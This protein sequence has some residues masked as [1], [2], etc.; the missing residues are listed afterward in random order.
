[1]HAQAHPA[2]ATLGGS[3]RGCGDPR[4]CCGQ[5]VLSGRPQ[6][7]L[8]AMTAAERCA[9]RAPPAAG[10]ALR[11]QRTK[12][13]RSRHMS[14]PN[15]CPYWLV[16]E[17]TLPHSRSPTHVMTAA[18]ADGLCLSPGHFC[19]AGPHPPRHARTSGAHIVIFAGALGSAGA[20][21][22][23]SPLSRGAFHWPRVAGWREP[24]CGL[25]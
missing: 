13:R 10:R 5:V 22:S 20:A 3:C 19:T 18:A 9:R 21:C 15:P 1:M 7:A 23:T 8:G 16:Q 24:R 2:S 4:A 14:R 12:P 6:A 11:R 17:G 25:L